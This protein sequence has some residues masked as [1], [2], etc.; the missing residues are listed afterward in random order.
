MRKNALVYVSI[1]LALAQSTSPAQSQQQII[2]NAN[3]AAIGMF[4]LSERNEQMSVTYGMWL[5]DSLY[6]NTIYKDKGSFLEKYK[7]CFVSKYEEL[8]AGFPNYLRTHTE[9]WHLGLTNNF[10]AFRSSYC[11]L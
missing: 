3:S 7:D 9:D 10:L 6:T 2:D 1:A 4:L 5:M 8:P 11:D